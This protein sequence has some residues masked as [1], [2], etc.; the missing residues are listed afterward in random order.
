[1]KAS[2]TGLFRAENAPAD[3]FAKSLRACGRAAAFSEPLA[4]D[5]R[6]DSHVFARYHGDLPCMDE[7]RLRAA[8]SP[9]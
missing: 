3:P 9:I 8:S 7:R 6:N 1:M 2:F 5:D 4:A